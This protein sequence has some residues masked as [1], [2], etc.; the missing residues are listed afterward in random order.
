MHCGEKL[1][2]VRRLSGSEIRRLLELRELIKVESF[3]LTTARQRRLLELLERSRP[4]KDGP[5]PLPEMSRGELVRA[6]RWRL[7]TIS[8]PTA[9]EAARLVQ[10]RRRKAQRTLQ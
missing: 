1:K 2:D 9:V 5:P 7:G 4:W 3:R 6:I 10:P 8:L